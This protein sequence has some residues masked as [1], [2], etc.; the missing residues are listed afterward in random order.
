MHC[1]EAAS[2]LYA[3]DFANDD[4][5]LARFWLLAHIVLFAPIAKAQSKRVVAHLRERVTSFMKGEFQ[6]LQDQALA[7]CQE[8]SSQWSTRSRA[9]EAPSAH[10]LR[11]MAK[12]DCMRV[13][14]Q[15][16][17]SSGIFQVTAD[18]VKDIE[19]SCPEPDRE[20]D[21]DWAQEAKELFQSKIDQR[22][23]EGNSQRLDLTRAAG[24]QNIQDLRR[25]KWQHRVT[26]MG[27]CKGTSVDGIRG[28]HVDMLLDF[29][30]KYLP[31]IL[32]AWAGQLLTPFVREWFRTTKGL[33]IN[34][35]DKQTKEVIGFRPLGITSFYRRLL[36]LEPCKEACAVYTA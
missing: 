1:M 12:Q 5:E 16:L 34:K 23:P 2:R 19:N 8:K 28:E 6:L 13:G 14:L 35:T 33:A 26:T 11:N 32:D 22:Q 7:A 10:M 30:M 3:E 18:N 29:D 15:R 25:A 20:L 24:D 9:D 27:K 4:L 21:H 17:E 36:S 31:L